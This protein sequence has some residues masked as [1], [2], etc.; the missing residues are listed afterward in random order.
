[1]EPIR[2]L[3][4][5]DDLYDTRFSTLC[6]KGI[7]RGLKAIDG[8]YYTRKDDECLYSALGIDV[9]GWDRLYKKRDNDTLVRSVRTK[10]YNLLME[11]IEDSQHTPRGYVNCANV[12]IAINEFPYTLSENAKREQVRI[13]Q[14]YLGPIQ[15]RWLNKPTKRLTPRFLVTN[16][17]HYILY[18]WNEWVL[19]QEDIAETE[20]ASLLPLTFIIPACL[21]N[22]PVQSDMHAYYEEVSGRSIHEMLEYAL[23]PGYTV[24]CQSVEYWNHPVRL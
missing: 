6:T 12:E 2:I 7:D 20:R 18:N 11:T 9:D 23:S 15:I 24:R 14:H 19:L 3:M 5:L 8:G 22:R 10:M 16:F 1:M 17:S 21:R 13:M 4:S